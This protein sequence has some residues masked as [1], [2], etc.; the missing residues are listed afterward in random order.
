MKAKFTPGPWNA[1]NTLNGFWIQGPSTDVTEV[2]SIATLATWDTIERQEAN[3]R[4]LAA[5]P[6]LLQTLEDLFTHC[7]MTHKYWGDG[8]NQKEADAAIVAARHTINK[9]K[10]GN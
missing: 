5:A 6:E 7:V 3:C 1:M 9:A 4:L 2:R 10:G 8:S